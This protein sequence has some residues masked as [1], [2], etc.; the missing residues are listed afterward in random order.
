MDELV[1]ALSGGNGAGKW[2][3]MAA[4]VAGA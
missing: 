1:T 2:T 4:L 3:T